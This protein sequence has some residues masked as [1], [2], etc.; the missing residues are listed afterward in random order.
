MGKGKKANKIFLFEKMN[1]LF[2]SEMVKSY[3][4]KQLVDP[5]NQLIWFCWPHFHAEITVRIR[6]SFKK[7]KKIKEFLKTTLFRMY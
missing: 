4:P 6:V 7:K 5:Q 1:F 3:I 2:N